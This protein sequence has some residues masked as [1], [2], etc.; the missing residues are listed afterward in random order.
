MKEVF[1]INHRQNEQIG[2]Q[3]REI[4]ALYKRI[5]GYLLT[6]DQLYK[7]CV[8]VERNYAKKEEGLRK[9]MRQY[10]FLIQEEKEKV[11]KLESALKALSTNNEAH[12]N[13]KCLELTKQ[14]SILEINLLR[15]TRKYA[16]LEE[17]EKMLRREYHAK[18]SDMAEKDRFVQDRINSLKEWN[19]RYT[20]SFFQ[21]RWV[22]WYMS[23]EGL[24]HWHL[25]VITGLPRYLLIKILV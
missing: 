8:R 20:S 19:I 1:E 21:F 11:A 4:E 25:C 5:R 13:N 7:D 22:L 3:K 2:H 6:Q 10:E 17:Q 18:D 16:N 24:E 9:T 15:L 12:I 23:T 14:N